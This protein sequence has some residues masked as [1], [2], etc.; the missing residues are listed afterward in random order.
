MHGFFTVGSVKVTSINLKSD[1]A[2]APGVV[3]S[4]VLRAVVYVI[5]DL[6]YIHVV[7]ANFKV[8]I[9]AVAFFDTFAGGV[10]RSGAVILSPEVVVSFPEEPGFVRTNDP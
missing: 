10:A 4:E 9:E 7:I 2:H 3:I 1:G 5:S 8:E 6:F